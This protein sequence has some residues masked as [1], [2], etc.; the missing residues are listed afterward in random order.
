MN[1]LDERQEDVLRLVEL[2]E[3]IKRDR[4]ERIREIEWEQRQSLA[5]KPRLALAGRPWDEERIVE[6]EV[7]YEGT[8]PPRRYR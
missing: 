7:I 8:P 5:P 3:D 6:R 4:R 1:G 2:S